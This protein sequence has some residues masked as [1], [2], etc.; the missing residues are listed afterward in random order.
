MARRNDAISN[1]K[2]YNPGLIETVLKRTEGNKAND[3]NYQSVGSFG[4]VLHGVCQI[5]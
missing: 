1:I 4:D 3:E 2:S 5:K